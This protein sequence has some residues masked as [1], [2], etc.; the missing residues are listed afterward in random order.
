MVDGFKFSCLNCR[1]LVKLDFD[2]REKVNTE[3]S[4]TNNCKV[5]MYKGLKITLH[6]SDRLVVSGSL[7]K[8]FNGNGMNHDQFTLSKVITAL[9]M[10]E[11]ALQIQLDRCVLHN[12]EFGVNV[13]PV[14]PI[15]ATLNYIFQHRGKSFSLEHNNNYRVCTHEQYHVKIYNKV[16]D[17][18]QRTDLNYTLSSKEKSILK[19]SLKQEFPNSILRYELKFKKMEKLNAIGIYTLADL[20]K[21]YWLNSVEEMLL[22]EW[23]QIL[24]FDFTLTDYK[25]IWKDENEWKVFNN[26]TD[27]HRRLKAMKEKVKT[28]SQNIYKQ[29]AQS[30]SDTWENLIIY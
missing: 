11:S 22:N 6:S 18:L 14:A 25:Q 29:Y 12:I 17:M 8:Y 24:A 4:E 10:L 20:E 9:K 28:S 21:E 30:I 1:H 2:F 23:E 15:Q 16:Y 5:A 26:R 7:H 3:T 13:K 19:K 27:K